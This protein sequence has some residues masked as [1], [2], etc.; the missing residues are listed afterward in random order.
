MENHFSESVY[1][2]QIT[3][4]QTA[5]T[6]NYKYSISSIYYPYRNACTSVTPMVLCTLNYSGKNCVRQTHIL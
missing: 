1:S 3:A 2:C 4:V 5:I 6:T